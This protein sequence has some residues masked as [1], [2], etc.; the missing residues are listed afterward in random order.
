MDL[1]NSLFP[2]VS[3]SEYDSV[4]VWEDGEKPWKILSSGEWGIFSQIMSLVESEE[5]VFIHP[6]A[7]IGECV[8]IETP[9]YIGKNC[10][11]RHSAFL[12]KG[13]WI[14]EGAVVGHSTE[15]K[16]S[17]LLPG[18][19]APHF[20][21]VG[22]SILGF[23]VNLGAGTKLSNVRN[24]LRNVI[25]TMRDGSR[26]ETGLRKMGSL[27]GNDSQIGCN[28]VT[29]PGSILEPNS[30]VAPNKTVN[31]WFEAKS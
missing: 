23:G 11:I 14:C 22:D 2:G 4:P 16:N 6:S 24:D 8:K 15:I 9:C 19:K 28:V 5:G 26:V 7:V 3:D 12:R 27:I 25:L 13:S 10:E 1:L 30:M 18:S 29:N 17:V 21:Y 20:N 31:G